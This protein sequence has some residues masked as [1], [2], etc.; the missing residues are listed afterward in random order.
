MT[1]PTIAL[2]LALVVS[3]TILL[4]LKMNTPV[5]RRL[6]LPLTTYSKLVIRQASTVVVKLLRRATRITSRLG[7]SLQGSLEC[8]ECALLQ[9]Q[10][11]I[12]RER[13]SELLS[14]LGGSGEEKEDEV[15]TETKK[16]LN[17]RIWSR[18]KN[19]LSKRAVTQYLNHM[20]EWE[21]KN[22]N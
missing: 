1:T 5:G 20:R 14:L 7:R 8:K 4:M 16:I 19:R 13:V 9:E 2:E 3:V 21:K 17:E 10:L 6:A 15:V 18:Q 11:D 12:E 22:E